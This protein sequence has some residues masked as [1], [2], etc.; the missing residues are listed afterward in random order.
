TEKV[1]FYEMKHDGYSLDDKRQKLENQ[2]DLQDIIAKYKIRNKTDFTDRK[3]E[4][5]FIPKE[6]IEG[7]NY[8]LSLSKYKEEE[9]VEQ[10]Y[11][12]PYDIIMKL[13]DIETDIN[14]ELVE[15][16]GMIE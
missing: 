6:E 15:L 1:W 16:Q 10:K 7:N 9:Y 5:F 13:K 3:G 12:N 4:C 11:E 14:K 2:S 8:D